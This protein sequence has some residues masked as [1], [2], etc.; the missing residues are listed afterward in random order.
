MTIGNKIRLLRTNKGLTQE[1]LAEQLHV[2]GQAVSK[3]ENETST[4]D[5]T[6]LPILADYFGI[7]IDDLITAY[8]NCSTDTVL[9]VIWAHVV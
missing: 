9:G 1:Q 7:P 3:W 4:P 5:I 6:M 8:K 2:S